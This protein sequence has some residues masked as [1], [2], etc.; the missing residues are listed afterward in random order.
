[1]FSDPKYSSP[2]VRCKYRLKWIWKT[3]L[4]VFMTLHKIMNIQVESLCQLTLFW[5]L[6]LFTEDLVVRPLFSDLNGLEMTV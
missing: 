3:G 4:P 6:V 1:M 5:G 2:I